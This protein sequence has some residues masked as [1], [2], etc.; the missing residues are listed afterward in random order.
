MQADDEVARLQRQPGRDDIAALEAFD[1]GIRC[2]RGVEH[3]IVDVDAKSRHTE[4]RSKLGHKMALAAANIDDATHAA[5]LETRGCR[6]EERAHLLALLGALP[7]SAVG[8]GNS[9][10]ATRAR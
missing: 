4:L 3:C 1:F 7:E 2:A 5:E 10:L 8:G 9:T 6:R